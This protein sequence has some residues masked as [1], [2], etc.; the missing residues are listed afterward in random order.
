V[1][2]SLFASAA[3]L[4]W[5]SE[6]LHDEA[7]VT[8]TCAW[9][10]P[11]RLGSGSIA[12][13]FQRP[14]CCSNKT[15]KVHSRLP[16]DAL[17]ILLLLLV[18]QDLDKE[19]GPGE[20]RSP[21]HRPKGPARGAKVQPL[22]QKNR[23][24]GTHSVHVCMAW[25]FGRPC[26]LD[27]Y[28]LFVLQRLLLGTARPEHECCRGASGADTE[29]GIHCKRWYDW[30]ADVPGINLDARLGCRQRLFVMDQL[31]ELNVIIVVCHD[32]CL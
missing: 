17:F 8:A 21:W 18:L 30:C 20:H 28:S 12:V 29:P 6:T 7:T 32:S 1:F 23:T 9:H 4:L 10:K 5:T 11:Q 14:Y 26:L 15:N 19:R 16:L 13:A 25:M 2:P 27:S 31:Q 3:E 24:Y 22:Q